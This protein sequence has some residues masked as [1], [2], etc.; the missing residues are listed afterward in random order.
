MINLNGD[1]SIRAG[2]HI[3]SDSVEFMVVLKPYEGKRRVLKELTEE[4]FVAHQEGHLIDPSFRIGSTEAQELIDSLWSCGYR[5]SQGSG[6]AGSLAATERHLKD[7]QKLT[8]TLID[9]QENS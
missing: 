5:P 3:W 2:K 7:M 6:S 9:R 1:V 8:F 4:D